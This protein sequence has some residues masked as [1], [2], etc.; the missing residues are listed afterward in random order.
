MA[1]CIKQGILRKR[2]MTAEKNNLTQ[3]CVVLVP[4]D[5]I[6]AAH[7]AVKKYELQASVE[8]EPALAMAEICL[9]NQHL[10]TNQAWGGAQKSAHLVLIHT[11]KLP[12]VVLL[13]SAI[14]KYLPTVNISELRD[15]RIVP[16]ENC[17][18][19]VDSLSE[20]PIVQSKEVD[21]DE[22]SM[23]LDN[24]PHEVEE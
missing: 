16:F 18:A 14:Q 17:G 22:L 1:L 5:R 12:D 8:H 24:K 13:I 6:D 10:K 11:Q 4:L 20:L 23:L 15:G 3:R 2:K 19:T 7:H 21:A 9:H